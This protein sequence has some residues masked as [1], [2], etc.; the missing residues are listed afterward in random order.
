M[1]IE[2]DDNDNEQKNFLAYK[3]L[4]DQMA[5]LA[6]GLDNNETSS[7]GFKDDNKGKT[8]YA[9]GSKPMA[10]M[11]KIDNKKNT[12]IKNSFNESDSKIQNISS[13]NN[14]SN[15]SIKNIKKN[16]RPIKKNLQKSST[17]EN[18]NPKKSQKKPKLNAQNQNKY[19]DKY[20]YEE[21]DKN[22]NNSISD[23]S[24]SED[25]PE[26][27]LIEVE[28]INPEE[29]DKESVASLSP[30]IL[31]KVLITKRRQHTIYERSIKNMKKKEIK[32]EKERNLIIEK[33]LKFLKPYPNMNK[34]SVELIIKKGEYIPIEN[35][36]AQ[37]HSQHLTQIILNEELNKMDKENKEEQ[38]IKNNINNNK[39]YEEKEWNEFV[40]KCLEWKKNIIYKRKA[41][42][43]TR[44]KRDKQINY[45]PIINGNSKKIMRKMMN[46]NN[47]SFDDVFTRLYNDYEE[48]KERQKVLNEKYMPC[49]N[50]M[51]NN[52]QFD[53]NM[54]N[55]KKYRNK[56]YDNGY[57]IFVTDE[58]KN[59]FFL[60]SQRTINEGKMQK[61]HKKAM[62]FVNKNKENEND[63]RNYY[64]I[65][66]NYYSKSYKPTQETN[67]NTITYMNT[68][69]NVNKNK[70]KR[71]IPTENNMTTETNLNT[72]QNNLPT[73]INILSDERKITNE[74]NGNN[75]SVTNNNAVLNEE[76]ILK[77]LDEAKLINK[78]K[79]ENEN[80]NSLYKINVNDSTPQNIKQNIIIPSNK[81]QD[82]FDI[83]EINEL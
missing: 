38:E 82:F 81:Y 69:V 47:S 46:K 61:K 62:K 79:Q 28:K 50:P 14:I 59:N 26:I 77:E 15:N 37:I 13:N 39:K 35:R 29:I 72:L 33:K 75:K 73:D 43:I 66:N 45:K 17:I 5:F 55:N 20:Q 58:N 51:I 8:K 44:N 40:E 74:I 48:H 41:A 54:A 11:S 49:F 10:S 2:K 7:K 27:E 16:P 30:F 23:E 76:R 65:S 34:K 18:N 24:L 25:L 57:E 83:E 12:K 68:E 9:K 70:N 56:S 31:E 42:E 6:L 67:N 63:I 52:F 71:Y 36:A 4:G 1:N 21:T 80:D 32:I 64:N 19:E 60:E 53:K 3:S 78:E 22:Q